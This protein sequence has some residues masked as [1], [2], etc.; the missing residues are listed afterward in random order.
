MQSTWPSVRYHGVSV[1]CLRN[2]CG[3][4]LPIL[5]WEKTFMDKSWRNWA[6]IGNNIFPGVKTSETGIFFSQACFELDFNSAPAFG[7]PSEGVGSSFLLILNSWLLNCT[8]HGIPRAVGSNNYLRRMFWFAASLTSIVLLL[9]QTSVMMQ[10]VF[11][12]PVTV[13]FQV[14]FWVP[15]VTS[16]RK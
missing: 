4:K 1:E 9:Y 5:E 10:D 3:I 14:I 8:A 15:V 11:K 6:C 13:S 2:G 12:Y 7:S 16:H